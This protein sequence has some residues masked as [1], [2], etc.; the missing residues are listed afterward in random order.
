MPEG[1]ASG[2]TQ[3]ILASDIDERHKKGSHSWRLRFEPG[4]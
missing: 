4:A 3:K 2:I 1:Y